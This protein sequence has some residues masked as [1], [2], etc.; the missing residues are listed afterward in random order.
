MKTI[1]V[2]NRKGG[3]G[4]TTKSRHLWFFGAEQNLRVLAI[5]LDNVQAN[6]T[7][8][9]RIIEA[10]NGLERP[11]DA[12]E[13]SGLFDVNNHLKPA[14]CGPNM[15]YVPSDPGVIDVERMDLGD[16]IEAAKQR[17]AEF[18]ADF[19]VCVIDTG[20]SVTNLLIAALAVSDFAVAPCKPD[21]DAIAGLEAFFENV[22]QVRDEA[23]INP[24]LAPLWVLP[25]QVSKS[26]AYHRE[27]LGL[28]RDA[29]GSHVL[30]VELY[31]RAATDI[32]KDRAVWR[33]TRG[34]STSDAALE[35]K[36]ACKHIYGMMGL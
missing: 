18:S 10:E 4:K 24:R 8:T 26:R 34:E 33:T 20:P 30:P 32:A 16:V 21:R 35:M 3:I 22:R 36:A 7:T 5:D 25:N 27:V 14:P 11:A 15:W 6:F 28:M 17:F 1:A 19:D 29:W 13:A 31:E 12:L 2:A 9:M 23:Q